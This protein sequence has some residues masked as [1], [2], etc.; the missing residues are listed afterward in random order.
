M[1]EEEVES[2]VASRSL[3]NNIMNDILRVRKMACGGVII[4]NTRLR[5]GESVCSRTVTQLINLAR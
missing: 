4:H 2:V 5:T 1:K 3:Q